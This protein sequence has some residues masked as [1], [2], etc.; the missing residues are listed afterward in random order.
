[1]NEEAPKESDFERSKKILEIMIQELED[2]KVK[3]EADI[4]KLQDKLSERR[5]A[6]LEAENMIQGHQKRLVE[7]KF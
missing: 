3:I 7:L 4:E 1:M 6:L 2:S 5:T